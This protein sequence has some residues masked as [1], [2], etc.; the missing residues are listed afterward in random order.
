M[1]RIYPPELLGAITILVFLFRPNFNIGDYPKKVISFIKASLALFTTFFI[2]FFTSQRPI[3][4]ANEIG[5]I[6]FLFFLFFIIVKT[7]DS[8]EKLKVI[9]L[10]MSITTLWVAV[11]G[12]FDLTLPETVHSR[13]T[14]YNRGQAGTFMMYFLFSI[15]AWIQSPFYLKEE[16]IKKILY[17]SALIIGLVFFATNVKF[18]ATVGLITGFFLF[19]LLKKKYKWLL[20]LALCPLLYFILPSFL[21]DKIDLIA[22]L[23][24]DKIY[25]HY[26]QGFLVKNYRLALQQFSQH[27]IFGIGL[28]GF[29]RVY[30][31]HEIHSYYLNIIVSTGIFGT[32]I[33]LFFLNKLFHFFHISQKTIENNNFAKLLSNF[34]PF[35]IGAAISWFYSYHLRSREFWLVMALITSI[36]IMSYQQ[37]QEQQIN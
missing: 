29:Y 30:H 8:L 36:Y 17:V 33:Y 4:T 23:F 31:S 2:S 19:I 37:K 25:S 22:Y 12:L 7:I 18:S 32:L 20:I 14:L 26:T 5:S 9:I 11:Y 35:F 28:G 34:L 1:K 16:I 24:Y 15:F 3:A 10:M 21:T 13:S 27:P 6:L